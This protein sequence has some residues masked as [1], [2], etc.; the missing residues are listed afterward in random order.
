MPFGSAGR[1]ASGPV[2]WPP[3]RPS[4]PAPTLAS[5]TEVLRIPAGIPRS[6]ELSATSG[7]SGTRVWLPSTR[8]P[9]FCKEPS[10]PRANSDAIMLTKW[11]RGS[12]GACECSRPDLSRLAAPCETL[13]QLRGQ[14]FGLRI[15]NVAQGIDDN[16]SEGVMLSGATRQPDDRIVIANRTQ[17]FYDRVGG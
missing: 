7:N 11:R 16:R 6:P 1:A 17:R 10:A 12:A 15:I 2:N 14:L 5:D 4:E 3:V 13:F 8:T 9:V